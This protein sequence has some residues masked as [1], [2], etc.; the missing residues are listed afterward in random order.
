VHA[1]PGFEDLRP[2]QRMNGQLWL[3][4][5]NVKIGARDKARALL[6]SI[7]GEALA[8]M[9]ARYGDLGMLCFL[10]E[11]YDEL[12]DTAAAAA[13]YTKLLP[14]A[15]R[16]AVGPAF[17]Y[18]GAVAHYLGILAARLGQRER[19]EQHFVLAESINLH[20]RMPLQAARTAALRAKLYD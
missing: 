18:D 4:R 16:N 19:A 3:A 1:P 11:I 13:L 8:C 17:D 7:A 15:E 9:P 20:L 6:A 2:T 10:A 12:E 5:L 14:Y